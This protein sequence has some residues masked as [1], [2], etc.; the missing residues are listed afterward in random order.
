M[1]QG[2]LY[3]LTNEERAAAK[4]EMRA[5]LIECARNRAIITYG[6]LSAMMHTVRIHPGSFIFTHLLTAVCQE[7]AANGNGM[8]CAL[9]VSKATGMPGGGYFRGM[10][11]LGRDTSDLEASWRAEVEAVFTHWQDR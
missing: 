8:L 3:R 6:D 4:A 2:Y 10:A 11:T 9:V 7:E 5:L 1:P